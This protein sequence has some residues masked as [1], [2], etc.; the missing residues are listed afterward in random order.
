MKIDLT[1]L[2]P[3]PLKPY[4]K[5]VYAPL[6]IATFL[7][8]DGFLTGDVAEWITR[9]AALIAVPGAVYGAENRAADGIAE[10]AAQDEYDDELL[11][12]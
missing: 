2:L 7:V 4:A 6:A 5:F 3:D 9:I 10:Q 11:D 8:A 12:A 1:A